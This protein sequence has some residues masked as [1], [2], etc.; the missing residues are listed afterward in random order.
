M[1]E[2]T[3]VGGTLV[4][5]DYPNSIPRKT[6]SKSSLNLTFSDRHGTAICTWPS[7][8]ARA[9]QQVA[10]RRPHYHNAERGGGRPIH[11]STLRV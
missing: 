7:G 8:V 9:T 2:L 1:L 10:L 5:P 11:Q 3:G 4:E 6:W